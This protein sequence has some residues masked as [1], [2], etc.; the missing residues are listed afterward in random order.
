V[1]AF[2]E[3]FS[4]SPTWQAQAALPAVRHRNASKPKMML[5]PS[6]GS[7]L[8]GMISCIKNNA[9]EFI[10]QGPI[11]SSAAATYAAYLLPAIPQL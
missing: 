6:H 7:N 11:L 4:Y 3:G 10:L 8:N 9:I 2:L 1:C 5:L